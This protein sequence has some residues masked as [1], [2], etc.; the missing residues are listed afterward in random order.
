MW[1]DDIQSILSIVAGKQYPIYH[2]MG[3]PQLVGPSLCQVYLHFRAFKK[4][5]NRPFKLFGKPP[6]QKNIST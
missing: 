2:S 4:F 1:V 6:A 5:K 3:K